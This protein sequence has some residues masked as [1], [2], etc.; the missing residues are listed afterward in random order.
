MAS[1]KKVMKTDSKGDYMPLYPEGET[2]VIYKKDEND[3]RRTFVKALVLLEAV[4]LLLVLLG[5]I[6][7]TYAR[8]RGTTETSS[9]DNCRSVPG[10]PCMAL[11]TNLTDF[12]L[13]EFNTIKIFHGDSKLMNRSAE[14]DA[15]FERIQTSTLTHYPALLP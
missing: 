2:S 6:A 8:G 3:Y 1:T 4:H 10:S 9:L 11:L 7:L 12:D 13:K 5:Y 15:L 14:S